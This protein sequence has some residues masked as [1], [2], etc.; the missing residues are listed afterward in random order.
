MKIRTMCLV[1]CLQSGAAFA[2]AL[3]PLPSAS[4]TPQAAQPAS[5]PVSQ[6][7]AVPSVPGVALQ[8]E[9]QPTEA[10][11]AHDE[12]VPTGSLQRFFRLS[13]S[14]RI[15]WPLSAGYYPFN[16][17][18][19]MPSL[20]LDGSQTV[21]VRSRWTLAL[22]GQLDLGGAVSDLRG[23]STGL[24]VR[25]LSVTAEARYH[26]HPRWYAHAKLAPGVAWA[27]ASVN[28]RAFARRTDDAALVALE[29]A[30]GLSFLVSEAR[31]PSKRPIRIWLSG[32]GG[33]V[34]STSHRWG[35]TT[36]DDEGREQPNN[37]G[38]F[39]LA[40]P[41]MRLALAGTY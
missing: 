31:H 40:A 16:S 34:V 26:L 37:V 4:D 7:A 39:S 15:D 20:S 3:Q 11:I 19:V 28:D 33:Y 10:A 8:S 21:L 13:G 17:R 23:I 41:M 9:P 14:I 6:P 12:T 25:K 1:F 35:L 5:Q 32:E 27:S 22:G 30:L 2:Q 29:G 24:G 38:S 18:E 36:G